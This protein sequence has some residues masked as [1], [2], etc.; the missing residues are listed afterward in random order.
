MHR[1]GEPGENLQFATYFRS[2]RHAAPPSPKTLNP[3]IARLDGSGTWT[4]DGTGVAADASAQST[5]MQI[6][7]AD[8]RTRIG[9]SIIV[10]LVDVTISGF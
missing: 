4:R 10:A 5:N 9:F 8:K 2:F 7:S 6:A 3:A 1:R